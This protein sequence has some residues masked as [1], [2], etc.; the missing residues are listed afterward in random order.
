MSYFV[1]LAVLTHPN[2]ESDLSCRL[3][4]PWSVLRPR[5]VTMAFSKGN[6]LARFFVYQQIKMMNQ[7][8]MEKILR[9]WN[10][11]RKGCEEEKVQELQGFAESF[12]FNTAISVFG[13]WP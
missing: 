2:Y 10:T 8:T 4:M 3:L 13:P 1:T 9:K 5:Q 7:G 11:I 12:T 6:P